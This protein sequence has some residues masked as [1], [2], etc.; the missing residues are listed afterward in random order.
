MTM[1]RSIGIAIVLGFL[2]IGT[3]LGRSQDAGSDRDHGQ[4]LAR[5]GGEDGKI[6]ALES[7]VKSLAEEDRHNK[8]QIQGLERHVQRMTEEDRRTDKKIQDLEKA[9]DRYLTRQMEEGR[10]DRKEI[11][12]LEEYVRKLTDQDQELRRQIRD[13]EDHVRK[14]ALECR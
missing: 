3:A 1:H 2:V 6:A 4:E 11:Q 5:A 14:A 12:V 13:L 8:R 7:Y 10:R 9:L